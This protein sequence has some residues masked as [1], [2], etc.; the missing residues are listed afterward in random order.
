MNEPDSDNYT[1]PELFADASGHIDDIEAG[2]T[3]DP[4]FG[5]DDNR[6][7]YATIA[8]ARSTQ[9]L[10]AAVLMLV[11]TLDGEP[12]EMDAWREVIP[13][14]PLKEC[15]SKEVRRPECAERHTEDCDY[16]DPV[17]AKPVKQE[18]TGPRVYVQDQRGKQGHI[19]SIVPMEEDGEVA[20]AEVQWYVPGV[21]PV[22]K[23][24][25]ALVFILPSQVDRC[26]NGQTRDVC[27]SGE[28]QCELCLADEDDE[29]EAIEESMGR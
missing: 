16:A 13:R 29:A 23:S 20:Q 12:Y 9:A 25:R 3:G 4:R 21:R 24:L 10:T 18:P 11:D 19:V 26:P 2:E 28:N 17:P 8:S 14:P 1:G 22:R 6:M 5:E 15:K 27:G 7:L